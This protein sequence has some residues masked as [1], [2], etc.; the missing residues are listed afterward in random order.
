MNFHKI[1]QPEDILKIKPFLDLYRKDFSDLT[2]PN[3]YM[4]R[5]LYPREYCIYDNTLIIREYS[6]TD[7]NDFRFYLP[8]GQ[9]VEGA[10][11]FIEHYCLNRHSPLIF[12]NL[13]LG[14]AQEVAAQYFCAEINYDRNWSDYVYSAEDMRS[15]KGKKFAGQRNHINKFRKLY[16]EYQYHQITENNI[17]SV[18]AFFYK[19]GQSKHFSSQDELTEYKL[20][21]EF[22]DKLFLL[23]GVG[24]YITCGE[25]IISVAMGEKRGNT[26]YVCI[27]KANREYQGAYQVMVQEFA[28]HNTDDKVCFINREEDMGKEGLRTSKLQYQPVEIKN[29][30]WVTVDTLFR[31]ISSPVKICG[32]RIE[33][34]EITDDDAESF[35]RLYIDDENNK[36]WGYNYKEDAP[37]V[38]NADYFINFAKQM[39]KTREEYSVAVRADGKFVGEAVFH[40]FDYFGNVE[41]GIRLLPEFQ[42]KGFATDAVKIM[43]DY[44][45]TTIGAK[46]I[47]MK[48][49]HQNEKSIK[50]IKNAGFTEVSRDDKFIYFSFKQEER[51]S[52]YDK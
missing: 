8:V 51:C 40:N 10:M 43:T 38:I 49:F 2:C 17:D 41:L 34:N 6:A 1:S 39:K 52:V 24:G 37:K 42:G 9:N 47:K 11:K 15:F 29:K 27:E 31:E 14:E 36:Y 26:L 20:N 16:G 30:Y 3:F 33:L 7:D 35:M 22:L 46:N 32:E 21:I 48:C 44:A 50:M 4:W 45:K 19:F 5:N 28:K 18:K 13:T 25:E 23:N 12:S